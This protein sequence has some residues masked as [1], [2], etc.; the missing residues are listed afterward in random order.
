MI[1]M[2]ND[3]AT[4]GTVRTQVQLKFDDKHIMPILNGEKTVT[5]RIGMESGDFEEGSPILFCDEGGDWFA[6]AGVVDRG[7]TTV[8]M[9]AKMDWDGHRNYDGVDEL[10][11]ELRSYYPDEEIGPNTK[12]EIIEWGELW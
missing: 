9:A 2:S 11:E 3:D 6:E 12:L 10:L 5:L 7:Y 1:P 4:G 8:E